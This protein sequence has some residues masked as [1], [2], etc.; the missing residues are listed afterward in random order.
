MFRRQTAGTSARVI[1]LIPITSVLMRRRV[2]DDS[3][4]TP[5]GPTVD[6][7]EA[8]EPEGRRPE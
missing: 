7:G 5:G 2:P 3:G 4:L 8:A 6:A 1:A